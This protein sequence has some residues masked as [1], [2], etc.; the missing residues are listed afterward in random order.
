MA[1]D[2]NEI[3]EMISK[4]LE[5]TVES[6]ENTPIEASENENNP[7][8]AVNSADTKGEY[9]PGSAAPKLPETEEKPEIEQEEEQKP[10]T[11]SIPK[12]KTKQP[13]YAFSTLLTIICI[14]LTASFAF[15]LLSREVSIQQQKTAI[16]EL[17]KSIDEL[18]TQRDSLFIKYNSSINMEIIRERA[19]Q[20]GMHEPAEDQIVDID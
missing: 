13:I 14:I 10:R 5:Y 18:R 16:L 7:D 12:P 3:A 2:L 8:N 17:E 4:S 11:K 1:S 6:N 20:L 9:I 19:E 15:F